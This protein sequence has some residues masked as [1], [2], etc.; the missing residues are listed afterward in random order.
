MNYLKVASIKKNYI[1][2]WPEVYI[3]TAGYQ[4]HGGLVM[5][6]NGGAVNT[7]L[8]ASIVKASEI[9]EGYVAIEPGVWVKPV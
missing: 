2:G 9:P 4:I 5:F 1:L 3:A 8:V 7:S 6:D